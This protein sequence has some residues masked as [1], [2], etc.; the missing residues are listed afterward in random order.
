MPDAVFCLF[1]LFFFKLCFNM[2][3]YAQQAHRILS[4]S[5]YELEDVSLT[6][7]FIF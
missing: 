7:E 4:V 2:W 3:S 5:L 1:S 6:L